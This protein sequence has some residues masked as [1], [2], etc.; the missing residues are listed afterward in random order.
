MLF[1]DYW[2]YSAF[3]TNSTAK[4]T[5]LHLSYL[6][7]L[8]TRRRADEKYI[9]NYNVDTMTYDDIK[10]HVFYPVC[11]NEYIRMINCVENEWDRTDVNET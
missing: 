6:A 3:V 4:G 8:L 9:P 2:T 7:Y 10:N 1:Q 5:L 11:T